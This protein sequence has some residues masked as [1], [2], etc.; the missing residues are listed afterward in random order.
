[1]RKQR[2]NYYKKSITLT[3]PFFRGKIIIIDLIMIQHLRFLNNVE[4]FVII[5]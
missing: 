2:E 3:E 5:V 1:M 4:P